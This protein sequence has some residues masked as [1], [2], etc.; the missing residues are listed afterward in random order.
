MQEVS[1]KELESIFSLFEWVADDM[2]ANHGND[3]PITK[4]LKRDLKVVGNLLEI[5]PDDFEEMSGFSLYEQWEF[6]F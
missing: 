6:D 3:C 4:M 5:D 2:K 1:K